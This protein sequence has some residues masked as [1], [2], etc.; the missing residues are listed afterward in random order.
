MS[1]EDYVKDLRQKLE[2]KK[3]FVEDQFEN[4]RPKI[5]KMMTGLNEKLTKA[6]LNESETHTEKEFGRQ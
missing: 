4:M 2:N 6:H 1:G 3:E 5:E